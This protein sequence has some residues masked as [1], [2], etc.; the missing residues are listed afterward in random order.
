MAILISDKVAFREK[1]MFRDQKEHYYYV[2]IMEVPIHPEDV[3]V[4]NVYT[5]STEFQNM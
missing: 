1:K 3:T 5:P 4:L 2:I